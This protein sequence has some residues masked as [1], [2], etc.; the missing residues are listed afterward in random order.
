MGLAILCGAG[1]LL[2]ATT[3]AYSFENVLAPNGPDGF[4][5]LGATVTQDTIGDTHSTHSMKYAIGVGGFVGA[6]TETL[7]PEALND[8]PGVTHILF[9]LTVTSTYTDTFADIGVTVFGHA[10]NAAGGA[11]FGHQVQFAD[12]VELAGLAPGTYTDRRIDLDLSVGPYRPGE[13]FDDIFG[14]G[15]NDLTVASAFQFY[16][17]KNV[18]TPLTVYIDNVRLVSDDIILDVDGN[19]TVDPL[20]DL[21]L[22]LRY[23]FGFRGNTLINGA[24]GVGCTRCD[25]PSIEAYLAT[26]VN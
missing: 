12:E 26:L 21:L 19:G 17:S 2:A 7:I 16:I 25:A 15:Q 11:Q 4:F 22:G 9:D 5:G 1:P 23:S 14:P 3:L 8:P 6:R 20:T 13:S 24:V 18:L 10:L